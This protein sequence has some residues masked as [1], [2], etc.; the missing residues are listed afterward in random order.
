MEVG[1]VAGRDQTRTTQ[2][3]L[4]ALL[5]LLRFV[6]SNDFPGFLIELKAI[7]QGQTPAHD[8][9]A[10]IW[11]EVRDFGDEVPGEMGDF[12]PQKW[13]MAPQALWTLT[14]PPLTDGSKAATWRLLFGMNRL[15]MTLSKTSENWIPGGRFTYR[16][17][18]PGICPRTPFLLSQR[19]VS[20][21]GPGFTGN[22]GV[23]R[24]AIHPHRGCEDAVYTFLFCRCISALLGITW[25]ALFGP[26][27]PY[28]Q[29][30]R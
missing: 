8:V 11:A 12:L 26:S 16:D 15:C 5:E 3:Q 22:P 21:L 29:I 20:Q 4:R 28:Q 14:H 24:C 27:R 18:F 13:A 1:V 19:G 23:A 9:E 7:N 6:K 10:F 25:A 17:V 30:S 2:R